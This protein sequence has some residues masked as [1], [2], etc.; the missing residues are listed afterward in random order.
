MKIV[1]A[2][3][4]A[5]EAR[6]RSDDAVRRLRAESGRRRALR[7]AGMSSC[8]LGT[9]V[10]L[11]LFVALQAR[12]IHWIAEANEARARAA[13]ACAHY[14]V[15]LAE[16]EA[17]QRDAMASAFDAEQKRSIDEWTFARA[18]TARRFAVEDGCESAPAVPP[19][20]PIEK[21]RVFP[22]SDVWYV[23]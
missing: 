14:Q 5:D 2:D 9:M 22:V 18:T 13:A 15:R 7:A 19:L 20:A 17:A 4:L 12:R 3:G 8:M 21:P 6:R 16:I 10:A 23:D 1:K 11:A